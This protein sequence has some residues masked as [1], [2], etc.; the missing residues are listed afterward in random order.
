MAKKSII[1]RE[2]KRALLVEK[3][4]VR[5]QELKRI[6]KSSTDF[7]AIAEAQVKLAKL[8]INSSPVRLTNR[9]AQCGRAHAVYQKFNLCRI[10]LREHAVIGDVPGLR[11]A[12]W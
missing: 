12:S 4:S 3:Y 1:E 8:P 5:R 11:K 7:D 2:R 10:C 9:C 6:I